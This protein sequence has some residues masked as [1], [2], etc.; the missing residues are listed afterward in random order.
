MGD[1]VDWRCAMKRIAVLG[2]L[3]CA[4]AVAAAPSPVSAAG[5]PTASTGGASSV[6]ASSAALAGTVDPQG[7]ATSW[8]FQYGTS[9]AYGS[10]T[11]SCNAG[12]GT[13]SVAVSSTLNGLV[14]ATTYHYR[15][16]ATNGSVTSTGSDATFTTAMAAPSVTDSPASTVTGNSAVLN[17]SVNPKGD[18]TNY[19]FQ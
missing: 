7:S 9:M 18:A 5:S 2:L 19:I 4:F 3:A 11:G 14:P 8:S 15:L 13:G 12:S 10:Q 17:A 1:D 6:T 16:V